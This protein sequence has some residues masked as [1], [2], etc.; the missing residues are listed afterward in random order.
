MYLADC[1]VHTSVSADA[2]VPMAELAKL[3][4]NAGMDEVC[5]TDHVEPEVV[6][7][8]RFDWDLLTAEFEKAQQA[9]GNQ[10]RLRMGIELGDAP[11]DYEAAE[12]LLQEAPPLD[13]VIG[14][15]HCLTPEMGG[16][17][18]YNYVPTNEREAY[19]GIEDYLS[20]LKKLVNWGKFSVLG[21]LTVPLRYFY[22]RGLTQIT[23]DPYED[24]VR[25]ILRTL[26]QKGC[27]M[28]LNTNLG[29]DPVPGAKWLKLYR[30]LGGEVITLGSDTHKPNAIGKGIREGQELLEACGFK[31]FCTFEKLQP[32]WHEL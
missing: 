30:E 19:L 9:M 13:F 10:I 20:Q 14:S 21:H 15:I 26:I 17:N 24:E 8:T 27:G 29:D 1:H 28:E 16:M 5:F 22:R 32:V 18:M 23:F 3:A 12:A 7:G 25:E 6:F 2:E 31:R 11:W 4:L